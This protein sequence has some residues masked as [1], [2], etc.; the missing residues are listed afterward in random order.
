MYV[1]H[2]IRICSF[3]KMAVDH[4]HKMRSVYSNKTKTSFCLVFTLHYICKKKLN[5]RMTVAPINILIINF[6]KKTCGLFDVLVCLSRLEWMV[7]MRWYLKQARGA[8]RM[9]TTSWCSTRYS[10][11]WPISMRCSSSWDAAPSAKWSNVGKRA[12]MKLSPSKYLKIIQ[13]M[14]DR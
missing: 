3:D 4:Q 11:P 10:I 5:N 12:P 2:E 1:R 9:E 6:K 13:V 14:P 7:R 8:A